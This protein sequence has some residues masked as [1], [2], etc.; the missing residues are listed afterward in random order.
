MVIDSSVLIQILFDE[1]GAE[2]AVRTLASSPQRLIATPTILETEIVVGSLQ[3]F[4]SGVVG[5]LLG[6]LRIEARPFEIDHV[7]DAKVAYARFGKRTG[8]P[9]RLNFGDCV[10]YALAKREGMVLAF[11]G[12]DFLHTDLEVLKLG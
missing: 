10:S 8:H 7:L 2:D 11:K 3:G 1:P 9:A 4:G 6:H 5:E 12:E